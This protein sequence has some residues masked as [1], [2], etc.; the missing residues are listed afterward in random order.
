[1]SRRLPSLTALRAFEA[2]ARHL[3]FTKAAEELYVTPAAISN[4]VRALEEH[5]GLTLFRRLTR[6]LVLTEAGQKALPPLRHGFDKLAEAAEGLEDLS[7]AG[8]LTVSAMP[9]FAAKWLVPRLDHFYQAHP[10]VD[11]R[12]VASMRHVDLARDGVDIGVRLGSGDFPGLDV[13]KLMDDQAIPVCSPRL[14]EGPNPL[15]TPGD[16]RHHVLL[17]VDFGDW[18]DWPMWLRAAGVDGIDATHGPRFNLP[19]L[20]VQAAIEG[21]GVALT[22]SVLVTNDLEAGRLV[23]PFDLAMEVDLAHYVVCRE[24]TVEQPRIAAFRDW[25]LKEAAA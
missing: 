24:S 16:L 9:F 19:G 20:P 1:M 2:A 12:L 17:H 6:A 14:L 21:Q 7:T 11:V 22:S 10:G 13:V 18:P 23:K 4:Q 25:I 5:F 8:M 3:S 15:R